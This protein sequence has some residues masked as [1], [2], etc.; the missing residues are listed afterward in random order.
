MASTD[1]IVDTSFFVAL[2]F[3]DAPQYEDACA[4]YERELEAT[5]VTTPVAV[6]E[7]DYLLRKYAGR[8]GERPVA[9]QLA[10]RALEVDWWEDATDPIWKLV[11]ARPEIG[12]ADASLVALAAHRRTTNVATYDHRH[13]RAFKPLTGED[14][15]TLLPA[16][17]D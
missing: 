11:D 15:F 1:V 10:T 16:D 2:W 13:F 14:T 7:M 9:A 6:A 4:W 3:E 5:L 8:A 17:A 12:V